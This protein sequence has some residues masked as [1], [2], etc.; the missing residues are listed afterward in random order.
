MHQTPKRSASNRRPRWA[1]VTA[2]G[3]AV[4]EA[5]LDPGLAICDPHHHLWRRPD[6]PYLLADFLR[7]AGG[8]HR[9]VSSVAVE[10]GAMYRGAGPSAR[11]TSVSRKLR[12]VTSV[13]PERSEAKSKDALDLPLP[14]HEGQRGDLDQPAFALRR[15]YQAT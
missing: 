13:R 12:T 7:D 5:P 6:N 2:G 11:A 10:C 15:R 1:A 3:G 9:I 8:G 4:D 14:D